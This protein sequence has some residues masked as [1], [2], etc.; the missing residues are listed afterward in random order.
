MSG[1]LSK[2]PFVWTKQAWLAATTP[3][4]IRKRKRGLELT[5]IDIAMDAWQNGY[6]L[7]TRKVAVLTDIAQKCANW[8]VAK[9]TKQSANSVWRLNAV[10]TLLNQV[11]ARLQFEQTPK[12][13]PQDAAQAFTQK[14]AAIF[15]E[16]KRIQKQYHFVGGPPLP[17]RPLQGGYALE[18]ES[19][20]GTQKTAAVS[21]TKVHDV[22]GRIK[23][24][25]P[26]FNALT[27]A[28]FEAYIKQVRR[29][30]VT[31]VKFFKKTDR[32]TKLI[33]VE[34]GLLMDGPKHLFDTSDGGFNKVYPYAIDEYGN[35]LSCN[36]TAPGVRAAFAKHERFNHSTLNAGKAVIC[37]GSIRATNGVLE[38][39]DTTSGHYQPTKEQLRNALQILYSCKIDLTNVTAEAVEFGGGWPGKKKKFLNSYNAAALEADLKAKPTKSVDITDH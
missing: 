36:E 11:F 15:E 22:I 12:P 19:Y 31:H 8:K 6:C 34:Q 32:I 26:D 13:Q 38:F 28:E 33:V 10:D 30:E 7:P 1:T 3:A 27:L 2:T 21:A 29:G 35:L 24:D 39:I 18:R 14:Q 16:R 37:A 17:V 23:T 9:Q 5:A 20:L 4:D 25:Q